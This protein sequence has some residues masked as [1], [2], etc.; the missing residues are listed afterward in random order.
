MYMLAV[1]VIIHQVNANAATCKL[2]GKQEREGNNWQI[3]DMNVHKFRRAEKRQA[4]QFHALPS[5]I[6]LPCSQH[7][8]IQDVVLQ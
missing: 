3:I 7:L 5:N 2:V 1:A 4:I 6:I 8:N